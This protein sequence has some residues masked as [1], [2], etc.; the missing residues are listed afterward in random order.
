MD[1]NE[2]RRRILKEENASWPRHITLCKN[3]TLL[4]AVDTTALQKAYDGTWRQPQSLHYY[5][6][7]GDLPES[8]RIRI[9]HIHRAL[10]HLPNRERTIVRLFSQGFTH[11]EIA[12]R[13]HCCR[14]RVGQ[15]LKQSIAKIRS[16]LRHLL[17]D[18]Q[19]GTF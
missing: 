15:L 1:I 17:H 13:V 10:S 18:Q 4:D 3:N 11:E 5:D 2:Y 8:V 16:N 7:S 6:P 14:R 19:G 12:T 9:E